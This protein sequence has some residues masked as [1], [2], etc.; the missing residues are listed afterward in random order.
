VVAVVPADVLTGPGCTAGSSVKMNPNPRSPNLSKRA[1]K[2]R[3]YDKTNID[4]GV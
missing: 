1:W 2:L 3:K 4:H